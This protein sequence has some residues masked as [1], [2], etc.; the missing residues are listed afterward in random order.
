[1]RLDKARFAAARASQITLAG[2]QITLRR[3][4]PWEVATAQAADQRL[5]ITWASSFAAG[6]DFLESDLLPGGVPD[7][8]DFDSETFRLWVEDHPETWKPLIDAVIG[9]YK[10]HE[11]ALAERGNV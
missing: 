1:M 3:P 8:V 10:A 2:H 11:T 9:A 4:T 7:P 6:W 5:D